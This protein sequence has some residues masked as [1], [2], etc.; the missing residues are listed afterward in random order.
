[1]ANELF[2][3]GDIP[4]RVPNHKVIWNFDYVILQGYLTD[5]N[6]NF[7]ISTNKVSMATKPGW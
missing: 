7:F 3:V 4:W 1:M 6:Q 5:E 2:K